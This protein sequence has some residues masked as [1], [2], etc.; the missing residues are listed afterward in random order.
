MGVDWN[1]KIEKF[2]LIKYCPRLY[3]IMLNWYSKYVNRDDL[4]EK[5]DRYPYGTIAGDGTEKNP[6]GF[7]NNQAAQGLLWALIPD[8]NKPSDLGKIETNL[9]NNND[10][11]GSKTNVLTGNPPRTL[12]DALD[13]YYPGKPLDFIPGPVTS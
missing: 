11:D 9:I 1:N 7:S 6:Y 10:T 4:P 8:L 12:K 2:G 13:K 5:I 3:N